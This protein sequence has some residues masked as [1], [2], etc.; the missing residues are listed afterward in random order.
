MDYANVTRLALFCSYIIAA[1]FEAFGYGN[2]EFWCGKLLPTT[3]TAEALD[4]SQVLISDKDYFL[5]PG[6]LDRSEAD[7]LRDIG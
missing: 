1:N 3:Y 5:V 6:T 2:K 7:T 4:L